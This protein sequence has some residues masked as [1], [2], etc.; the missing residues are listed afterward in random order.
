[1]AFFTSTGLAALRCLTRAS[2]IFTEV[3]ASLSLARTSNPC[4]FAGF[5]RG[6]RTFASSCGPL[7]QV[8]FKD[9]AFS[10]QAKPSRVSSE[11]F[12]KIAL[13]RGIPETFA[14]AL[15][16]LEKPEAIDVAKAREQHAAYVDKLKGES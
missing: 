5:V 1:M 6:W 7:L 8:S 14:E 11:D 12:T 2:R 10:G 9:N 13:V 15:T 16:L 3:T 4:D